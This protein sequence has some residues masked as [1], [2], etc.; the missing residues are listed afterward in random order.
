[1][2][3]SNKIIKSDAC[4]IVAAQLYPVDPDELFQ[5]CWLDYRE[6]EINQNFNPDNPIRYFIVMMKNK[7]IA[8]KKQIKTVEIKDVAEVK[9]EENNIDFET[10]NEW[11][12]SDSGN[13][14]E[15]FLKNILTLAI[16]CD[17]INQ[18]CK[19]SE[20][21]RWSFWKYRKIAIN[22]FYEY[23]RNT[24]NNDCYRNLMG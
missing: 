3:G 17:D 9:N 4:K 12:E 1:M 19:V 6:R 21:S 14:N 15:M 24:I 2:L 5:D 10:L 16:Y 18:A 23:Y 20:M 13:D 22:K 7:S 8:W 11:L